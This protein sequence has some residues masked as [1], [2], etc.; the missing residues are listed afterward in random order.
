MTELYLED[1]RCRPLR[2]LGQVLDIRR[3]VFCKV[4]LM[5]GELPEELLDAQ[6]S[7]LVDALLNCENIIMLKV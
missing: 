3:F 6:L 5:A 1:G 4:H 2:L 7:Q